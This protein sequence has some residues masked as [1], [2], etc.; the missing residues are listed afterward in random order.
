MSYTVVTEC[1][2]L[3]GVAA[4]SERRAWQ[5]PGMEIVPVSAT[6]GDPGV[7]CEGSMMTNSS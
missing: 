7:Q 5:T 4:T 6:A 3:P 1:Q 2:P